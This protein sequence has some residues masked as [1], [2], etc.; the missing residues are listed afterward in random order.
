MDFDEEMLVQFE[1]MMLQK[2]KKKPVVKR[3]PL[4]FEAANHELP[5]KS[6]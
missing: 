6:K 3:S 5:R 4:I 1:L 2:K